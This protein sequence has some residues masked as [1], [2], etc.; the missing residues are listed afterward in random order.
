MT[1]LLADRV[2]DVIL[3]LHQQ[4][5]QRQGTVGLVH[6]WAIRFDRVQA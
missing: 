4:D 5:L 1:V 2:S 6:A 3:T